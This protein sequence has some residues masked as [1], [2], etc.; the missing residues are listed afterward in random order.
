VRQAHS[1]AIRKLA[2]ISIG[3]T[4]EISGLHVH[5]H[6]HL[7]PNLDHR[8]LRNADCNAATSTD[9]PAP[10]R[11]NTFPPLASDSSTAPPSSVGVNT[12]S[13]AVFNSTN[14]IGRC[15]TQ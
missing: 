12:N 13:G 2:S 4:P 6:P 5:Q 11:I 9:L 10:G 1:R 3:A 14:A 7:W 8:E 15:A